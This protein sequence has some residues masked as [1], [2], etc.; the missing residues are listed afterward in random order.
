MCVGL[1]VCVSC[2]SSDLITFYFIIHFLAGFRTHS[3]PSQQPP[4]CASP[5]SSSF[6]LPFPFP[7]LLLLLLCRTFCWH[8]G[9]FHCFN[10]QLCVHFQCEASRGDLATNPYADLL[11]SPA[12]PLPFPPRAL[13]TNLAQTG[14]SI[15]GL[16]EKSQH[17]AAS[18]RGLLV[19]LR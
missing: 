15:V 4:S 6:L 13:L 3:S 17:G 2:L 7:S 12:S 16:N 1:L 19:I 14:A 8:F 10:C 11:P 18:S 9:T 5:S